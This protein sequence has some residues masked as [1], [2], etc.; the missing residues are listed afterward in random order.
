MKVG[1]HLRNGS[2]F[3]K[4]TLSAGPVERWQLLWDLNFVS[5]IFRPLFVLWEQ[6]GKLA[7][8]G[9][10]TQRRV[11]TLIGAVTVHINQDLHRLCND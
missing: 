9:K 6:N 7:F 10:P 1:G 11:R 2:T 8:A 5:G 4:S 3:G